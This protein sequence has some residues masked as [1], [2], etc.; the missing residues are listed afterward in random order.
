MDLTSTLPLPPLMTAAALVAQRVLSGRSTPSRATS[1]FGGVI[2]AAGVGA[3]VA[4]VAQFRSTGTTLDP[5]RPG[6]ASV[7][8]TRGIYRYSRNP[9]YLG[10]GL[11][12]LGYAVH[13]RC[14]MAV[15]PAAAWL[16]LMDGV[17]IP[18]EEDALAERFGSRYGDYSATVRRWI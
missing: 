6:G 1:V 8:V 5:S 11:A 15:I 3:M 4:G 7:L 10:D 9:I 18:R 14:V 2:G 17:Q 12:L 13:R 16:V